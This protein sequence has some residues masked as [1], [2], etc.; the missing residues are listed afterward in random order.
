MGTID[1]SLRNLLVFAGVLTAAGLAWRYMTTG[2][3]TRNPVESLWG[4][5]LETAPVNILGYDVKTVYGPSDSETV[6]P[7]TVSVSEKS[8]AS[9]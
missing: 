3:L 1:W 6:L 8:G 4:E 5:D 2:R 9:V 7:V